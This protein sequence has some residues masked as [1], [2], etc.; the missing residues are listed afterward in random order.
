MRVPYP[1]PVIAREGW[2]FLGVAL[3]LSLG[4]AWFAGWAWSVPFWLAALFVLGAAD[5]VSM[6]IRI[7]LVQLQ[8]PEAMRGRVGAVNFLFIN[9]SNQLGQFESGVAAALLG[10]VPSVL[11]GGLG[12]ENAYALA[13][14]R[15]KTASLGIRSI[16]DLAR[17]AGSMTIAGDYEFF[18]RP[19]WEALRSAYGLS[20]RQQRQMQ[21]EFMYEAVSH[22][23]VDVIAGYTSDSRMAQFDLVVLDTPPTAN[24]LDFLEAP[25]RIATA[26]S[27]PALGWFARPQKGSKLFSFQRIRSG[28]ALLMR[29]FAKFV[30]SRF[31]DDAGAFLAG[32][33]EAPRVLGRRAA[34]P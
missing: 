32:H 12:F 6:V 23:E 27:S 22:G 9:A 34:A 24:A 20:F 15:A 11:L 25:N 3:A 30:G 21:A 10:V 7:G 17:H 8:T 14:P 28:G 31:L 16:A 13:M 19:E 5:M 1:H 33:P 2:P 18:G 29:R 4:V 26:V